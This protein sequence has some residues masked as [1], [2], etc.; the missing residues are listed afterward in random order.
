MSH[1][2]PKPTF[3]LVIEALPRPDG[4]DADGIGRLRAIL[5]ALLRGYRFRCVTAERVAPA[6]EGA[7]PA[8]LPADET[9][10]TPAICSEVP[11]L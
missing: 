5:K 4:R 6:T 7:Q 9:S 1:R 3:K 2:P 10:I 8:A 11:T